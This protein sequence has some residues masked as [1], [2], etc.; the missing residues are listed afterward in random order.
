ML[1]HQPVL[2]HPEDLGWGQE[3]VCQDKVEKSIFMVVE[4][5][6]FYVLIC[7]SMEF[8][9]RFRSCLGPYDFGGFSFV[10]HV[11]FSYLLA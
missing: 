8:E 7:M 3:P 4:G 6:F 1:T 9:L 5:G 2:S 10:F 11:C